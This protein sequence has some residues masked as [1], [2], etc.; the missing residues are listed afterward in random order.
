MKLHAPFMF[1]SVSLLLIACAST[2]PASSTLS[3]SPA[4][5]AVSPTSPA[6]VPSPPVITVVTDGLLGPI[7]LAALPDGSLLVAEEGTGGRDDSA[8]VSLIT[9][10]GRIGRFISG[11]PSSR[12]SG[13]LAGVPL[14]SLGPDGR[15]LYV[16]NFGQGHLWTLTLDDDQL[17]NGFD[18]PTTPYTPDDMGE[19]MLPLNNVMLVNPFDMTF[20]A[21]GTPVVSDASGNGVARENPDGTTLFFHRFAEL[22]NP[23]QPSDP[24][25]AVP[26]GIIRMQDEYWVTLMGGCPYPAGSGQ[27]VAIDEARN[28]RTILDGL[29]LPIDVAQGPDGTIWV[30]EFATFPPGGDCFS[31]RDYQAESGRLS[32]LTQDGQLETVVDHLDFPGAV[33]P[34]ADG[35]L[36]VSEVL[37]GRVLHITF[38]DSQR[39]TDRTGEAQ[40]RSAAR[41]DISDPDATLTAL[42]AAYDLHP[43]PGADQRE[44]E[45]PLSELGQLLFFDPIL[46]GDQ[47][48]SCATCHHPAFA[49]ADGRVLPIGTGGEGLGPERRFL[50]DVALAADADARRRATA[51]SPAE[52]WVN[53]P[54]IGQFVPR[55]SPTIL[56]SALLDVQFWDGRVQGYAL[57]SESASSESAASQS[58][59]VKTP[60]RGVNEMAMTDPLATQALFPVTS[61]HEMAGASFGGLPPLTIR[62]NLLERLRDNDEYVDRFRAV[63]SGE[64]ETADQAVTLTRLAAALAAFERRFIYTAAPWDEY[65]T[66]DANA[67]TPEQKRGALLF[68][69]AVNPA[70]N[71]A[72][73]HSGDLFTDQSFHDLLVPQLGPGKGHGYSGRED[74]GRAAVTFDTRDRYAFRT[75]SLR[76]VELTAPY[77]HTGAYPT[78]EDV[79]HHHAAAEELAQVYDPSAFEI[80]PD[81]YSSYQPLDEE[82][83]TADPMLFPPMLLTDADVA[84]LAAFLTALT[85]PAARDLM[86]FVPTNVP[87]GLPLD[88]TTLP[89]RAV[90]PAADNANQP[91]SDENAAARLRPQQAADFTFTDVAEAAGL[92]FTHGAFAAAISADMVAAMGG[93]LCWLD[94]DNDG[95]L[96]LYLVNSHATDEAAMWQ[97]QGGLPRNALYR[98]LGENGEDVRFEDVSAG[99]GA[100]L[101]LRGNGCL[102][103]DLNSDGFT[104]LYIT[105]D[106]PNALLWNN[107]DGTFT[108]GAAAAGMA[109]PEWNS[110]AVAGDLNGDGLPDLFVAAYIDFARRIPKP[111]G[112]FPQDYYGL[113]DHL[114]LNQ[115]DGTFV[116]VAE[117][118]GL[119][120][121]ERG[122]GALFLDVDADGDLDLYIANDGHP[123]RLYRND[124]VADDPGFHLTDITATAGVGDS[125]SGMGVAGGDYDGDGRTDLFITNWERELNALYRNEGNVD[126]NLVFQYSTFRIGIS[127]LGNGITGW[128]TRLADFD[129]DTDTDLL[130]TN[131]RVPVTNLETDPE[132]MRY[133]RNRSANPSSAPMQPGSFLEGTEP[134]GLKELGPLLGRGSAVADY[135]N[136]GDLDVAVNQISGPVTLLRNDL[137]ERSSDNTHW[138]ILDPGA[139]TPGLRA[140]VT[141]A[142]GRTLARESYAG[143]SYLATE[144]FRL[145]FGLGDWTSVT[146]V[147]ITWPGGKEIVLEDVPAD[148][149]LRIRAEE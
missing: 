136:D 81:L 110:A 58:A 15:T 26:T 88:D 66:G 53:N 20:R 5:P 69:G 70:V 3:P 33:L 72:T 50:A 62:T 77:F 146:R 11:L 127:G 89:V 118:A 76:N 86:A 80:S 137:M 32:R 38:D 149:A 41:A 37:P 139:P 19:A 138:L 22:E 113:S 111:S 57:P 52:G 36:Y 49:M 7:G 9:P 39:R 112:A 34:M 54:F 115:G 145:H 30:L 28:Q 17:R 60:E 40:P 134:V 63:F 131:G 73:C 59:T 140:V 12:D 10:D 74:W 46:S 99:S 16:G 91:T 122:L 108:E 18:L 21:D 98:N 75:P 117:E 105:A 119:L 142:D 120:Y 55:N 23:T 71:C 4:S 2:S 43:Y 27:L 97:E 96:D 78:L 67:L 83:R 95:W 42:I 114:Y 148:Q 107:G 82:E 103:A 31:G 147:A 24:I 56:N 125:G 14:V 126:G 102:A 100:D 35:S 106:G 109:A 68:F 51:D 65:L 1:L 47:N 121:E 144:D 132:L 129:H 93:G 143:S 84:D 87:S 8:G 101:A 64:D 61:L 85:D 130:I 133:Y 48:I 94:Y 92:G 79:I 29:N 116:D 104:D 13:D 128:G 124:P 141:L 44:G 25:E 45:T 6:P 123:N 135:D 90:A